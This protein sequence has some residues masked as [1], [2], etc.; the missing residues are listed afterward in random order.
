MTRLIWDAAGTHRFEQGVDRGVLY[1]PNGTVVPWNGLTGVDEDTS[2]TIIEEYYLDGVK[3]L[4]RRDA[5]D[6]SGTLKA[7]TYPDEFLPFDGNGEFNPGIFAADQPV[8]GTFG[9]SYRTKMG[10][11]S[12]VEASY[13]IHVLYNQTAKISGKSFS[14][15]SKAV[16]P[17]EFAWS[18]TGV[19]MAVVGYRPTCHVVIDS[20]RLR[21]GVLTVLENALY[22]SSSTAAYLPDPAT[23]VALQQSVP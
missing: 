18:I 6:F 21:A 19:P 5:G 15:A 20:S 16:T 12:N 14:T 13:K 8:M 23:L 1:L 3:Y 9:L 7:I 11:D 2:D 4:V 17:A 22:G 10:N